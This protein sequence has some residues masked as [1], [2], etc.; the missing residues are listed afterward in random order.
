[1][2]GEVTALDV[3]MQHQVVSRE[4]SKAILDCIEALGAEKL[5][6]EKSVA[7]IQAWHPEDAKLPDAGKIAWMDEDERLA[8]FEKRDTA[9]RLSRNVKDYMRTITQTKQFYTGV[10]M[11]SQKLEGSSD[12]LA[13]LD[14]L[15]DSQMANIAM[16]LRGEATVVP[17]ATEIDAVVDDD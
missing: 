12:E 13:K 5:C 10:K 2:A 1:M 7:Y 3:T 16:V 14:N 8:L 6:I 11:K 15:T 9:L 17:I 4:G